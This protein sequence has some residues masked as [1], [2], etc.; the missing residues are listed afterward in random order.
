MSDKV[1]RILDG[2][3]TLWIRHPA[4]TFGKIVTAVAYPDRIEKVSDQVFEERL[5]K[6]AEIET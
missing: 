4:W 5:A 2:V 1:A 3:W 6:L